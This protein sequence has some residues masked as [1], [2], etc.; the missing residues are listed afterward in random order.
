[1]QADCACAHRNFFIER[2][3][4]FHHEGYRARKDA[5]GFYLRGQ[6]HFIQTIKKV[7]FALWGA[8]P[9]SDNSS[10]KIIA[11]NE[12]KQVRVTTKITFVDYLIGAFTSIV[13]IVP[14]TMT[15][16]GNQ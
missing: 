2:R 1:V 10:A 13:S 6:A 16:E 14:A 9:I 7:G 15:V 11:E 5:G 12:L 4:L 8:V 3:R